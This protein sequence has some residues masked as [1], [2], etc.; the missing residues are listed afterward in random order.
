MKL[1]DATGVTEEEQE[2]VAVS[3]QPLELTALVMDICTTNNQVSD[4][5]T[6]ER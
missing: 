1:S 5:Y 4:N 6:I 2:L 3:G